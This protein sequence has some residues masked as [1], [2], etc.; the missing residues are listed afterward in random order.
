MDNKIIKIFLKIISSICFHDLPGQTI[1]YLAKCPIK[2]K[3]KEV[4]ILFDT[5]W[6]FFKFH[7][8][9]Y[10]FK[11]LHIR[12]SICY[13]ELLPQSKSLSPLSQIPSHFQFFLVLLL[14]ITMTFSFLTRPNLS[15]QKYLKPFQRFC[16]YFLYIFYI[17]KETS[18]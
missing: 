1:H 12:K 6:Y 8:S 16:S 3:K 13:A 17:L 18:L 2:K 14:F 5:T 11:F 10:V 4:S 9:S 15:S 7:Y